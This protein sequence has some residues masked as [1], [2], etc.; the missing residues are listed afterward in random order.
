[1]RGFE[2]QGDL[3]GASEALE[4][5][6][7]AFGER[8]AWHRSIEIWERQQKLARRLQNDEAATRTLARLALAYAH[9]GDAR[10]ALELV[11][12][13]YRTD[14]SGEVRG[15]RHLYVGQALVALGRY[16]D[17][18]QTLQ[19]AEEL[20][21]T[22]E[23]STPFSAEVHAA[24]AA[25]ILSRRGQETTSGTPPA[26]LAQN[27][28]KA[29][30]QSNKWP[31]LR[32]RAL[33]LEAQARRMGD[34]PD[35]SDGRGWWR[36]VQRSLEAARAVGAHWEESTTL[37]E[38]AVGLEAQGDPRARGYRARAEKLLEQ[39]SPSV[40]PLTATHTV[41]RPSVVANKQGTQ[42]LRLPTPVPTRLPEV[43]A[44]KRRWKSLLDLS[45][46]ISSTLDL[47]DLLER[48]VDLGLEVTGAQRGFLMLLEIEP[49]EPTLGL[50]PDALPGDRAEGRHIN[51]KVA[52][53]VG[54]AEEGEE[55]FGGSRSVID[56]VLLSGES[57]LMGDAR[58]DPTFG[59]K[60]SIAG[61]Q[62]RSV[63]A[64]PLVR[65]PLLLGVLYVDNPLVSGLIRE[66]ER[67]LLEVFATQAAIALDNARA[68]QEIAQLERNVSKENVRLKEH[69]R[70]SARP[71]Q[72]VGDSPAIRKALER[73][74]RAAKTQST[75]LITGETG[76][77][78]E[79]VAR[80][81]HELSDR[82]EAPLVKIDCAALPATLL[83]SELFGYE[84][85]AFTGA[86]K[87][88]IGKFEMAQ[89]GTVFL[90][91]IGNIPLDLQV[92]L[93]QVLQ[94]RSFFRLGGR[95][96]IE[97]D[98]RVVAATN[99]NLEEAV[100]EGGFREDLFYRL[101]VVPV[102]IPPLRER[103][104]D[105]SRLVHHFIERYNRSL[106]R[107]VT[108]VPDDVMQTLRNYP[109]PGNIR[110]LEN[111]IERS[112]VLAEGDTL[113]LAGLPSGK[114]D[115]PTATAPEAAAAP[116]VGSSA[117][118]A[119]FAMDESISLSDGVRQYKIAR[120]TSALKNAEGNRAEA[121]RQLG[122]H[123]QNLSRLFKQ[124]DI[125]PDDL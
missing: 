81:V 84:R 117:G 10:H 82:C 73:I 99:R 5:L 86:D 57:V 61:Q 65:G 2:D 113:I 47:N 39:G 102:W 63:L 87:R 85:G 62:I 97:V 18:D 15:I 12:H 52:R 44:E 45:L 42:R 121:A 25:A 29:L 54:G 66:R 34:M 93:L 119:G 98:V 74:A 107:E 112:L 115:M 72:I 116:D 59:K 32:P 1:M 79:L 120:I 19:R 69:M 68:Y 31:L 125:E 58:S 77:G 60:G 33:R 28:D 92:K 20:L 96:A 78:K 4:E 8:G 56:K 43:L 104:D 30:R 46:A 91:E 3:W 50:V 105:I 7:R 40:V 109:W 37:V 67:E 124:L 70:D 118:D 90:D 41:P 22:D 55:G 95:S 36:A 48:V 26:A 100:K 6:G 38:A 53:R 110:E 23:Q 13:E 101:N 122:I 11:A 71:G 111:V 88:R 21:V 89:G 94:N 83:E 14:A 114:I 75:V 17:G 24:R 27:L 103:A 80:A 106:G 16:D 35:R 64:V 51:L 108:T 49:S 9:V 123:R 76:V